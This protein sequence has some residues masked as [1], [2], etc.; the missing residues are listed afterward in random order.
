MALSKVLGVY[1]LTRDVELRYLNSGSAVAKLGL[2]NSSKHKKQ[3]GTIAEE[4]CF[5]DGSIFGKMAEIANQYLI[6][7]SKIFINAELKQETWEKDGQKQSRYT[8]KI[9]SFEMLDSKPSDNQKTQRPQEDE[10]N[11]HLK[12]NR[13]K[14]KVEHRIPEID[15]DEDE[16]PF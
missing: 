1:R 2:V 4:S 9:D 15:I 6:K 13:T 7:G 12:D 16:I 8:L 14:P 5:I 3:D 10:E 11:Y